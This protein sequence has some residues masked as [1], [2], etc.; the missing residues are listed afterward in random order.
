MKAPVDKIIKRTIDDYGRF[1]GYVKKPNGVQCLLWLIA[2]VGELAH[3]VRGELGGLC[4]EEDNILADMDEL[5][6][7]ADAVVS[8]QDA[9]K[10]NHGRTG[11]SDVRSEI[12]DILMILY[13]F[14]YA[15]D[16]HLPFELLLTKMAEKG[17]VPK[18][19]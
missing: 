9:W 4:P 5:G 3:A 2:E 10:R 12:P 16:G 18:D 13:Q 11:R 7:Y 19:E 14:S 8:I 17:F 15:Y 1:A 6:M